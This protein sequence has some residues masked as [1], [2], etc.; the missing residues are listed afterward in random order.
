[1]NMKKF[2]YMVQVE[3]EHYALK[4]EISFLNVY[5]QMSDVLSIVRRRR[6]ENPKILIVG[7]GDDLLKIILKEKF[8]YTIKT[9]DIDADLKPDFVGSIDEIDTVILEKFDVIVCA[10][11]L[12]HLPFEYFAKSLEKMK[13]ISS[14]SIIYLPIAQFGFRLK[15]E[16]FPVFS[17]SIN[18]L[19]TWFFKVHKFDGQHYWEIGTKGYPLPFIRRVMRKHFKIENEY[20]AKN[21]MYSYNFVLKSNK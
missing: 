16:L 17:K 8:G 13:N 6:I 9:F 20:N 14:Y 18:F 4:D 12:E 7:V 1:M 10:H 2:K 3:T 21:W 19:S 15:F 5:N 11:V